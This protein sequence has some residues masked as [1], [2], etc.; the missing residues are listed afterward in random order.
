MSGVASCKQCG[1]SEIDIDASRGDAVCTKCGTVLEESIMVSEVAFADDGHG[2]SSAI[3][4]FVSADS[5]GGGGLSVSANGFHHGAVKESREITLRAAKKKIQEMA[6]ILRLILPLACLG[7]RLFRDDANDYDSFLLC[8][9]NQHCVD[10][11]FNFFKM[12][13]HKQLTK[14]RKNA[15]TIAACVYMTCRLEATPRKLCDA[16]V[17]CKSVESLQN[18]PRCQLGLSVVF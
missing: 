9:L 13:L 1:N 16:H 17:K 10:V 12:A 2:G 3:G 15:L 18:D 5:R 7:F 11:A 14:G 8:R 4:Q 6:E